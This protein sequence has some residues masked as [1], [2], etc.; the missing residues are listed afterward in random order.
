MW[1]LVSVGSLDEDCYSLNHSLGVLKKGLC[2]L[3]MRNRLT[4]GKFISLATTYCLYFL[5]C[6]IMVTTRLEQ[7][8]ILYFLMGGSV[9]CAIE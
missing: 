5:G 8:G 7:Q 9:K 6:S 4:L 1:Q 2:L 3:I